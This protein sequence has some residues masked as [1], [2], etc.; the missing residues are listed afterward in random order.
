MY[1]YMVT[2]IYIYDIHN[3]CVYIYTH[4]ST[5]IMM[6]ALKKNIKRPQEQGCL[7]T[8]EAVAE[9]GVFWVGGS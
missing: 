4:L 2:D 8:L 7:S 6:A 1:I 5:S 9:A 3:I